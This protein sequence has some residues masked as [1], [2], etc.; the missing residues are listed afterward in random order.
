[1]TEQSPLPP[2]TRERL[3]AIETR[4]GHQVDDHDLRYWPVLKDWLL[5]YQHKRAKR[6]DTQ[7]EPSE[8]LVAG[9]LVSAFLVSLLIFAVR[10]LQ[11]RLFSAPALAFSATSRLRIDANGTGDEFV[12]CASALEK[13]SVP[14]LYYTAKDRLLA[15]PFA[16]RCHENLLVAAL[17]LLDKVQRWHRKVPSPSPHPIAKI[18]AQE[19]LIPAN[20]IEQ[21]MALFDRRVRAYHRLLSW[22]R[23]RHIY[24]VSAY[25]KTDIVYAARRMGIMVSEIQHGMLAPFH[26]SYRYSGLK[27]GW[28]QALPNRLVV[29]SPFWQK[30]QSR[31]DY[32]PLIVSPLV[33]KEAPRSEISTGRPYLL[34]SGQKLAYE[35]LANFIAEFRA[36]QACSGLDLIY[37]CHPSEDP[38]QISQR[39]D[40]GNDPRI[41]IQPFVSSTHTRALISGAQKHLSVYSS[42]HVDALEIKGETYVM[43]VPEFAAQTDLFNGIEGVRTFS[44]LQELLHGPDKT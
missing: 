11:Q 19:T 22:L 27:K 6:Q 8:P 30:T 23:P 15:A 35:R 1:M 42:C 12:A 10:I 2:I 5:K 33:V 32:A 37:A 41:K 21:A 39:L 13:R 24:V 25:T 43:L 31:F 3:Q 14:S 34:F 4:L 40:A 26:P 20:E 38:K 7:I 16:W 29:N 28:G 18:I 9:K 36:N 17:V 44:S